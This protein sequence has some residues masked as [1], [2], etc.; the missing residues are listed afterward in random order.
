MQDEP[1][2]GDVVEPQ[3]Q[4]DPPHEPPEPDPPA[5]D[6][7]PHDAPKLPGPA[8]LRPLEDT[9]GH[10]VVLWAPKPARGKRAEYQEVVALKAHDPDR[11]KRAVMDPSHPAAAFLRERAGEG[12]GILLRAVPAMHW[13]AEVEPTTYVRPDPVL[14]IR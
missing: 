6:D 4:L 8:R 13:P 12:G 1:T 7:P 10:Y 5:E 11:A 3:P 2:T 14:T 9:R